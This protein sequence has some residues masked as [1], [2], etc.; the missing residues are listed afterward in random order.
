[1]SDIEIIRGYG[2]IPPPAGNTKYPFAQL[3]VGDA[4]IISADAKRVA[5]AAGVWAGRNG[6]RFV[7][8]SQPDGR[9]L[10]VRVA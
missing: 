7:T 4:A 1:M 9:T 3:E 5:S 6:G 10:V 8:R 2:T